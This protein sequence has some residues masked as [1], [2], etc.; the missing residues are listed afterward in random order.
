MPKFDSFNIERKGREG[1]HAVTQSMVDFLTMHPDA[2]CG[3]NAFIANI[4]VCDDSYSN[5]ADHAASYLNALLKT[6]FKSDKYDD[7]VVQ[8][9]EGGGGGE[10]ERGGDID[11][12]SGGGDDD[13]DDT[14]SDGLGTAVATGTRS[15][16]G[17]AP[18]TSRAMITPANLNN[19]TPGGDRTR[20]VGRVGRRGRSAGS[21]AEEEGSGNAIVRQLH[22]D[23]VDDPRTGQGRDGDDSAAKDGK[24]GAGGIVVG[25]EEGAKG[26]VG[27]LE[28]ANSFAFDENSDRLKQ[29]KDA[30]RQA[31]TRNQTVAHEQFCIDL[32]H[33]DAYPNETGNADDEEDKDDEEEM[34]RFLP[35]TA[36]GLVLFAFRKLV[37]CIKT[38]H[39]MVLGD[40]VG[41]PTEADGIAVIFGDE[42]MRRLAVARKA[43][44]NDDELCEFETMT[45][46]AMVR[47][48]MA[49]RQVGREVLR[50]PKGLLEAT[51]EQWP[52]AAAL[53][54]AIVGTAEEPASASSSSADAEVSLPVA[55]LGGA[56]R[57]DI[58]RAVEYMQQGMKHGAEGDWAATPAVLHC[59]AKDKVGDT[60]SGR[61]LGGVLFN[62]TLS[63][64]SSTY[65]VALTIEKDTQKYR[66]IFPFKS[67]AGMV[68]RDKGGA[69]QITLKDGTP[70][71]WYR[72]MATSPFKFK[73][74][75]GTQELR[76]TGLD[77]LSLSGNAASRAANEQPSVIR[78][79]FKTPKDVDAAAKNIQ[80][81]A[82][83]SLG[84]AFNREI[85]CD[86][87]RDSFLARGCRRVGHGNN[88]GTFA[89]DTDVRNIDAATKGRGGGGE[90]DGGGGGGSKGGTDHTPAGAG[91]GG[92]V[93]RKRQSTARRGD[94]GNAHQTP[95]HLLAEPSLTVKALQECDRRGDALLMSGGDANDGSIGDA[96]TGGLT[97]D[98]DS[99]QCG[100]PSFSTL[101]PYCAEKVVYAVIVEKNNITQRQ[102]YTPMW[103]AVAD[104]DAGDN[105]D[106]WGE[107][108]V[109]N[110]PKRHGDVHVAFRPVVGR[111]A[112]GI[113]P[114]KFAEA[115]P[116]EVNNEWLVDAEAKS[117]G[118][119]PPDKNTTL[120][121]IPISNADAL[122]FAGPSNEEHTG[123]VTRDDDSGQWHWNVRIYVVALGFDGKT[124]G[125]LVV[126]VTGTLNLTTYHNCLPDNVCNVHIFQGSFSWE[127]DSDVPPGTSPQISFQGLWEA[128]QIQVSARSSAA[129]LPVHGINSK[130]T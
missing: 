23:A 128:L 59:E 14:R 50:A 119:R 47:D 52:H 78:V 67:I 107:S 80:I 117:H 71:L 48:A 122:L 77:R 11:S 66:T 61:G 3:L 126:S 2:R 8:Q 57:T 18:G 87:A 120:L 90:G 19:S 86:C 68:L 130:R 20:G 37:L 43:G 102:Q 73:V 94:R 4:A 95:M 42:T 113:C 99:N 31:R 40:G 91:G 65:S 21:G 38:A 64:Y 104:G 6:C 58:E 79:W 5:I 121:K 17:G 76:R 70:V 56:T 44:D 53:Y 16:K 32:V 98:G 62:P 116:F 72:R 13:D 1:K 24:D 39:P 12:G 26:C 46:V 81:F 115:D 114:S 60:G 35:N 106:G 129:S 88:R 74:L 111:V 101:C 27:S 125:K 89:T 100:A 30:F 25:G 103:T 7:D 10:K 83:V 85:E 9:H 29:V 124:Y 49:V 105:G 36:A 22:T 110:C 123:T 75:V 45:A 96:E 82:T 97:F 51:R 93:G 54:A 41:D 33:L 34:E 28:W 84:D 127:T 15:T 63:V 55:G 118:N 92:D 109:L 108:H 69:V 112:G